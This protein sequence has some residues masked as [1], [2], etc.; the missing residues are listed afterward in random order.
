M[1]KLNKILW[2]ILSFIIGVIYDA[3]AYDMSYTDMSTALNLFGDTCKKEKCTVTVSCPQGTV[4]LL[5]TQFD[6]ATGKNAGQYSDSGTC[7]DNQVCATNRTTPSACS[8]TQTASNTTTA[9]YPSELKCQTF[10]CPNNGTMS[11]VAYVEKL[12]FKH[13]E[14]F[15]CVFAKDGGSS[16]KIFSF[17]ATGITADSGYKKYYGSTGTDRN[18]KYSA[19][20]TKLTNNAITDCYKSVQTGSDDKGHFTYESPQRC[21][22]E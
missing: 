21:Y 1:N 8:N 7:T 12:T 11:K 19:Y 6:T 4:T 15:G 20:W 5:V 10:T 14:E 9:I 2:G 18:T 16:A 22:Y 3:K 13:S 17:V